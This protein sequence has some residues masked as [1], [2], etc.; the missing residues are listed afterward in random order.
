M[1]K[2]ILTVV[3]VMGLNVAVAQTFSQGE[4][5]VIA[6]VSY[7]NLA[8]ST[9]KG[10]EVRKKAILGLKGD[11]FILHNLAL[12]AGINYHYDNENNNNNNSLSGDIGAKFYVW[13]YIYGG[14]F[15]QGLYDYGNINNSGRAEIGVN[16]YFSENVFIEPAL[17]FQRGE[18]SLSALEKKSYT[19]IGLI[20]SIGVNF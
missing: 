10:K 6:R 9:A 16:C 3:A 20:L 8:I 12:T 1:K 7:G 13:D 5:A 11:F 14:L 15:Y 19:A 18:Y 17:Y 2:W 4:R